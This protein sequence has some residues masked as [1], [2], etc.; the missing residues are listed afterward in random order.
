M[1]LPLFLLAFA[2]FWKSSTCIRCYECVAELSYTAIEH[3]CDNFDGSGKYIV[4]CPNSNMCY[5]R[6]TSWESSNGLTSKSYHRGCA[7]QS[8]NGDQ[9]RINGK[10]Q[11]VNDIHDV[12]DEGCKMDADEERITKTMHCYCRG[13]LC[14]GSAKTVTHLSAFLFIIIAYLVIS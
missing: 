1:E 5:K 3:I 12:Y 4:D 8:V 2:L 7:A 6:V 13:E 9:K 10:W 14:N 11:M